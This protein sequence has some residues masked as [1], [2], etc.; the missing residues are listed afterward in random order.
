M[1]ENLS[2]RNATFFGML[3]DQHPGCMLVYRLKTMQLVYANPASHQILPRTAA[4][5]KW[6]PFFDEDS[7]QMMKIQIDLMRRSAMLDSFEARTRLLDMPDSHAHVTV[8]GKSVFL[9]SDVYLLLCLPDAT[10]VMKD[11]SNVPST[12]RD[13]FHRLAQ[14]IMEPLRTVWTYLQLLEKTSAK[15]LDDPGKK[16]LHF[17]IQGTQRLKRAVD[18][19][20]YY[21][22]ALVRPSVQSETP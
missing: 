5:R 8:I 13:D 7:R 14:E 1:G 21:D 15:H 20:H 18:S 2:N 22:N 6:F 17:I 12:Q 16:F 3:F 9:E 19:L 4:A 11:S 10:G